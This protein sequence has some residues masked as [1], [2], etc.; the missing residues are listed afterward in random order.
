MTQTW[1]KP[2]E[3]DGK[4]ASPKI[5]GAK[6]RTLPHPTQVGSVLRAI[7]EVRIQTAGLRFHICDQPT[8]WGPL[9]LCTHPQ[10]CLR[11]GATFR[12]QTPDPRRR[13]KPRRHPEP[14]HPPGAL[15]PIRDSPPTQG[16][17]HPHP[18]GPSTFPDPHT[19]RRYH[20]GPSPAPSPRGALVLDLQPPERGKSVP[21]PRAAAPW[22]QPGGR[23]GPLPLVS[24]RS[25]GA[26]TCSCAGSHR[27]TQREDPRTRRDELVGSVG[28]SW[29]SSGGWH[30]VGG[31]SPS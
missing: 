17:P 20:V 1:E 21:L 6:E 5:P 11:G 3:R 14:T 9:G 23:P 7:A 8:L 12:G 29:L 30:V 26:S 19:Q 22:G 16:P 27:R 15:H 10:S 31:H 2:G 24:L 28:T 4:R 13:T 25:E 18:K